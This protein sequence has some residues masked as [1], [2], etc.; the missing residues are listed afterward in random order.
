MP[1]EE[2]LRK[3]Q[4]MVEAGIGDHAKQQILQI[5]DKVSLLKPPERLLLYLRMPGGTPE[6]DPL[7]QP[8]NPLGTRSEINHTINWVRSHLEHDPKVSIPKQDV[9]NDYLSYCE[10]VN[11]KPLSTADFGKVMKQV[12]P[13][14]RPRRLGTRGHSRYCYAAMRKATK[15]DPPRLPDLSVNAGGHGELTETV[16]DESWKVIKT[17]AEGLLNST[18]TS[19]KELAN[20][21]NKYH[22][23][24]PAANSS[25]LLLQKKLLQ[26]ESKEKRKYV[27][28]SPLKKR[29]KKKRRSSSSSESAAVPSMASDNSIVD[30]KQEVIDPIVQS[31][32][33]DVQ[34]SLMTTPLQGGPPQLQQQPQQMVPM[35]LVATEHANNNN[36]NLQ[37]HHKIQGTNLACDNNDLVVGCS[38]TKNLVAPNLSSPICAPSNTNIAALNV[39]DSPGSKVNANLTENLIIKS[40]LNSVKE[41]I[42]D[43]YDSKIYCKKVRQAQQAKGLWNP[44]SSNIIHSTGNAPM[45]A[46][47]GM[48]N[49]VPNYPVMKSGEGLMGPPAQIDS[50]HPEHSVGFKRTI[51]NNGLS[52]VKS[53][54]PSQHRRAK[55][56]DQNG[57][58]DLIQDQEMSG[59]PKDGNG[60]SVLPENLGLPRERVI[61]ICNMDKHELDD[62]LNEGENSQD[63]EAELLQYFQQE[64]GEDKSPSSGEIPNYVNYKNQSFP[65]LENYQLYGNNKIEKKTNNQNEEEINQLRYYLQQNLHNTKDGEG[66]GMNKSPMEQAGPYSGMYPGGSAS[67][68]LA[69]MSQRHHGAPSDER[70]G[71]R[72]C[73]ADQMN[74]NLTNNNNN[75]TP[76]RGPRRKINMNARSCV[77]NSP[78]TRRKNFSFVPIS[79]G[80]QHNS[81]DYS[82][83]ISPRN[84]P[85]VRKPPLHKQQSLPGTD[86]HGVSDPVLGSVGSGFGKA[87][88]FSNPISS[89]APP[90]PSLV[91]QR[92]RFGTT[93]LVQGSVMPV[94]SAGGGLTAD[95]QFLQ[96][97]DMQCRGQNMMSCN[98][99]GN[100]ES[101]S[102]SV[103]LHCRS[104]PAFNNSNNFPGFSSACSSVAQTPVP[105]EFADFND[106]S[107]LDIFADTSQPSIKL[108]TSEIAPILDDITSSESALGVPD[109]L[110]NDF[111][112]KNNN[113]SISRSV[114]STP[115]PMNNYKLKTTSCCEPNKPGG[116]NKMYDVSKSVPTTPSAINTSSFRYS[117]EFNK[118]FLI[119]GNTIDSSPKMYTRSVAPSVAV[120]T[121]NLPSNVVD[122]AT[123]SKLL[124]NALPEN[125]DELSNYGVTESIIG[126]DILSNL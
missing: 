104:S 99:S 113:S 41:E 96:S 60:E 110:P 122:T 25:R 109:L 42:P 68:S 15:L 50:V 78:N 114:P 36:H 119:N 107:I 52:M 105:P 29:R 73:T 72:C 16:D 58:T 100:G 116:S 44:T 30:I 57:K 117:P 90:S 81:V 26:R 103:P 66:P 111:D 38:T 35:N 87:T 70:S 9:Y 1:E 43:T 82:P 18:F 33:V 121:T 4:Q 97:A 62:Y 32:L 37:K 98:I 88:D 69:M 74:Q 19:L 89:S 92:F 22:S 46:V 94:F 112:I 84:T 77:P 27:D 53:P 45:L 6:T 67:A 54:S 28:T 83:F 49:A 124:T 56:L 11:I 10:R 93:P 65:L 75:V 17:W 106:A 80:G 101:R 12:F 85:A 2:K 55:K 8:Q 91:Q 31:P 21:I 118:D 108:E 59:L 40:P 48:Q 14:I 125:V 7:R 76:L 39:K 71:L 79:P 3:L 47:P 23:S 123:P 61:S 20:Y 51:N 126:S 86:H 5:L 120:V 13:E 95:P 115:L 63:Q 64:D 24:S 34:T 102:Q